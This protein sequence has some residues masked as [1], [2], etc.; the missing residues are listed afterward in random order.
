MVM[1]VEAKQSR[2]G[3]IERLAA[4]G[5]HGRVVGNPRELTNVHSHG[6]KRLKAGA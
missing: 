3:Q 5:Q 6:S 2:M 1:K 4:Y